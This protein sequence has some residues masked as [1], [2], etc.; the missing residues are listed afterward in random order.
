MGGAAS[1]S[2][3]PL[4]LLPTIQSETL[5]NLCGFA[6]RGTICLFRRRRPWLRIAVAPASLSLPP[7]GVRLFLLPPPPVMITAA[8]RTGSRVEIDLYLPRFPRKKVSFTPYDD[9]SP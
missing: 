9:D 2:S 1:L 3:L 8:A 5:I 7:F 4:S 6:F